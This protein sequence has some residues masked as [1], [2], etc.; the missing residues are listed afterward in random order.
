MGVI[1]LL[2]GV[3]AVGKT[4]VFERLR[5][6]RPDIEIVHTASALMRRLGISTGDYQALRALPDVVKNRENG[7]LI[8]DYAAQLAPTQTVVFDAHYLNLIRGE[9]KPTIQ[10]D[11]L[12]VLNGM[13][14]LDGHPSAI[15]DRIKNDGRDRQLFPAKSIPPTEEK[16]MI[17]TFMAATRKEFE[18]LAAHHGIPHQVIHNKQGD[19]GVAIQAFLH[20]DQA[21]RGLKTS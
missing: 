2:G 13:V 5:H 11:W 14:L 19:L 3:N 6:A 17:Q 10:G 16:R 7:Q 18:R 20:F 1:Y 9:L 21:V 8:I 12:R 4:A 15:Y